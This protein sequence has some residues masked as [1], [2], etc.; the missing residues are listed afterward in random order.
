MINKIVINTKIKG[1]FEVSKE[2]VFELIGIN[3]PLIY[4]YLK[5]K[6]DSK[7]HKFKP[8]KNRLNVSSIDEHVFSDD[9]FIYIF[10]CKIDD[11]TNTDLITIIEKLKERANTKNSNLEIIEVPN[12]MVWDIE[13]N[14]GIEKLIKVKYRYLR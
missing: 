9:T 1:K 11:R 12:K 4:K 6:K 10:E 14:N 3:S 8:Y 7:Q 2:V 13:N 5:S